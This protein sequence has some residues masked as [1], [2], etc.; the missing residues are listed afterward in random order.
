M[1]KSAATNAKQDGNKEHAGRLSVP[2]V[3]SPAHQEAKG[4]VPA[5]ATTA[6][7]VLAKVKGT[8]PVASSVIPKAKSPASPTAP[9]VH[10]KV[11]STRT[12][13]PSAISAPHSAHPSEKASA[14]PTNPVGDQHPSRG[15]AR[16]CRIC[17]LG[18]PG[19]I[20][21]CQCRGSFAFVHASCLN[22]WLETTNQERC[23]ICRFKYEMTKKKKNLCNFLSQEGKFTE[24]KDSISGHTFALYMCLLGLTISYHICKLLFK[25]LVK[26]ASILSSISL[27]SH[28]DEMCKWLSIV[29]ALMT[30]FWLLYFAVRFVIYLVQEIRAFCEWRDKH[31][32]IRVKIN[33]KHGRPEALSPPANLARNAGLGNRPNAMP[34]AVA[35]LT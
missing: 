30:T 2:P 10:A 3:K 15:L 20:T 5:V 27:S 11:K 26:V 7:P 14:C 33:T 13:S 31:F 23:D 32:N 29:F 9:A 24:Y 1:K 21:P 34:D 22:Q 19:L 35:K 17:N 4:K 28:S 16:R 12:T 18:E 25:K 8:S 6:T